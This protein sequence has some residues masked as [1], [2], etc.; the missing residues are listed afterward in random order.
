MKEITLPSHKLLYKENPMNQSNLKANIQS[1]CKAQENVLQMCH[2]LL[3]IYFWLDEK[4]AQ[5]F[6]NPIIKHG[7]ARL[8]SKLV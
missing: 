1:Q 6:C 4:V 5:V 8:E 7:N 3:W 2:K